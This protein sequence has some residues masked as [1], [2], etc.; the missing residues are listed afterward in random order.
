MAQ[1]LIVA[2]FDSVDIAEKLDHVWVESISS[3]LAPRS[4]AFILEAQ[5]T[6]P[7]EVD[8]IVR[9]YGGS[10]VRQPLD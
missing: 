4:V 8:N 7:F 9:G 2:V 10:I 1:E 6:T 3:K 5:E